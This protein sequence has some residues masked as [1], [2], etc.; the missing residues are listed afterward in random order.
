MER[1]LI[2]G[3]GLHMK[4]YSFVIITYNCKNYLVNCLE[5][6]NNQIGFS[7][8]EYEAVVVD[9]G[10]NDGTYEN[11]QKINLT[12]SLKYIYID[13]TKESCRNVARN[14]GWKN[15]EGEFIIF[16]DADMIVNKDYLQNLH[17]CYEMD[18]DISVVGMR[19]MLDESV[20][21]KEVFNGSVFSKFN[22]AKPEM[23]Y[24]EERHYYFNKLSYNPSSFTKM[25]LYF[26]SCNVSVP[27]KYLQL[28][29]GFNESLPGWGFDDQELGYRLTR[30]GVKLILNQK[31]EGLHQY[32]GEVYGSPRSPNRVFEQYKNITIIYRIHPDLEKVLPKLKLLVCSYLKLTTRMNIIVKKTSRKHIIHVK[33]TSSLEDVKALIK[34]LANIKGNDIVVYDHIENSDLHIWV[35]FLRGKE[36]LVKYFPVSRILDKKSIKTHKKYLKKK[37]PNNRLIWIIKIFFLVYIKCKR[38]MKA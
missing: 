5:S 25:W 32:H 15:A 6:L 8:D 3:G 16:L 38:G 30:A 36:S 34:E 28:T 23:K 24:Y 29:G 11:I 22:I 31:L 2:Y 21:H 14:K 20:Y 17:M 12:Y 18:K 27:K 10:S 35:Q 33:Y 19:F 13:R 4:K 9:D 26:H 7:S 37:Y 1:A